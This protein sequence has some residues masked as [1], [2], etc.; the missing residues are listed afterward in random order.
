MSE[1]V[2]DRHYDTVGNYHWTGVLSGEHIDKIL[3]ENVGFK[4]SEC[5]SDGHCENNCP[6]FM[7]CDWIRE[8][9]ED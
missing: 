1:Q 6:Y 9:M 2:Y 5:K 4:M 7:D 3:V 8:Q